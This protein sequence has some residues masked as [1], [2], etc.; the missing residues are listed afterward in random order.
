MY[1]AVVSVTEKSSSIH[2]DP[3]SR[4]HR[5]SEDIQCTAAAF[6]DSNL[7]QQCSTKAP[8]DDG[9]IKRSLDK[10]AEGAVRLCTDRT[11]RENEES[12]PYGIRRIRES[13]T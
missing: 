10:R 2:D 9:L 5:V 4:C 6:E 1:L 13:G 3:R 11:E 7:A 8:R 12:R